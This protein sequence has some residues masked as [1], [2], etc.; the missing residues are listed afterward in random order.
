MLNPIRDIYFRRMQRLRGE[1][2]DYYTYELDQETRHKIVGIILDH[3]YNR[4][5]RDPLMQFRSI[6]PHEEF[7]TLVITLE[8]ELGRSISSAHSITDKLQ[9]FLFNCNVDEFLSVIELLT[10][11]K[12]HQ[13]MV[14]RDDP[15][16]YTEILENTNSFVDKI[17]ETFRVDKIGYELVRVN[18]PK[19]PFIVVPFN[20]RYLHLETIKRPMSLMYDEEFKGALNEFEDALDEYRKE[21]YKDAIHK[22]NNAYESTLKTILD[23]K[24]VEYTEYDKIPHLIDKIRDESDIIDPKLNS[25]FDSVWSVLKN[26]PLTIRN[27]VAHGQGQEIKEIQKSYSDFVLR[28]VGTYIV[29]LIERY[30]ETK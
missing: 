28:L 14:C 3:E 19:L 22:A 9:D 29:F 12:V 27:I 17:N 15:E 23:L 7:E 13:I 18:L 5:G 20:S 26:G 25:A 2:P 21:E 10:S 6:G 24:N 11:L 16:Y 8:R 30:K 1:L 4:S